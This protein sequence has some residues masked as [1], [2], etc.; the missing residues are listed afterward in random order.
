[1][2]VTVI[3]FGTFWLVCC[4]DCAWRSDPTSTWQDA[5]EFRRAHACPLEPVLRIDYVPRSA[6]E[7]VAVF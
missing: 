3:S 7:P 6:V 5:E 2:R 1:M 4:P